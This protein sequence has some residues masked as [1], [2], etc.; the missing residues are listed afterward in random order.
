MNLL[1]HFILL[2]G[3]NGG[4]LTFVGIDTPAGIDGAARIR[5]PLPV[6]VTSD[7]AIYERKLFVQVSLQYRKTLR[8]RLDC[9]VIVFQSSQEPGR[10]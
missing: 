8:E 10:H 1:D 4:D 3:S 9:N 7:N 5:R 2:V 6:V